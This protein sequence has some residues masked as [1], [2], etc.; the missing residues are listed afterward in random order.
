MDK[1]V[2]EGISPEDMFV[3]IERES[4]GASSC[5]DGNRSVRME[6]KSCFKGMGE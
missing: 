3:R 1:K 5:Q 6:S 4:G 2:I